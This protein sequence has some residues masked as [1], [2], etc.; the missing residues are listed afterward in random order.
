MHHNAISLKVKVHGEKRGRGV[1]KFN[2]SLLQDQVFQENV[3]DVI[4]KVKLENAKLDIQMQWELCKIKIREY[5]IKY[6]IDK[7][8]KDKIEIVNLEQE[9]KLLSERECSAS[10]EIIDKM[11]TINNKI[12]RW[13]TQK[14][15][16]AF[17]RSREKWLEKG[18]RS[19]KYF[20]QLEKRRGKKKE[21]DYVEMNGKVYKENILKIIHQ[22]YVN[23]YAVKEN[24]HIELNQ[25][26]DVN[27][28]S[29]E[30]ADSCEG[31]LTEKECWDAL[32]CMN[33]NK[34]PGCDGLKGTG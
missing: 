31:L 34:S 6:A 18:E 15:K 13:Y 29:E 12:D 21:I 19:T 1:W 2:S 25:Y 20:L 17:I 4:R 27:P 16:G 28:L 30:E 3:K 14:C 22:Y 8:K 23:L 5:S 7:H 9:Y 33:L 24:N 10:Q 11:K 26:I 32:K